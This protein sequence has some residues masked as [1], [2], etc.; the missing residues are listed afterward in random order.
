MTMSSTEVVRAAPQGVAT[1]TMWDRERIELVKRTIA[2]GVS[3]DELALFM[4]VVQRTGLDPFARQVYAIKRYDSR[5]RREVMTIQTSIDGYRLVA[6]RSADYAGQV[7]PWWCGDDGGW[8]DVWLEEDTP[9]AARVGVLRRGFS[10]VLYATAHFS[11]YAQ[12][13][14]DGDLAGQWRTMP[15]LM[16]AK[17]AEALALRRAFPQE[18]SNLYTDDEMSQADRVAPNAEPI[19]PAIPRPL[20]SDRVARFLTACEEAGVNPAL[21]VREGT[22]GRTTDPGEVLTSEMPMLTKAFTDAK[23]RVDASDSSTSAEDAEPGDQRHRDDAPGSDDEPHEFI[24][25]APATRAQVGKIKQEYTRLGLGDNDLRETQL[26][27]THQVIGRSVESHNDLTMDE[28]RTLLDALT[29]A[30]NADDVR[31]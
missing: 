13:T 19:E 22:S 4:Q 11:E 17:C 12:R 21:V 9:K 24:F 14:R 25:R 5:E 10:E 3:D 26:E 7:G 18:L 28:A 15:V 6:Q 1:A 31:F 30:Q 27:L 20:S 23:D 8:R 16:I 29:R 2:K